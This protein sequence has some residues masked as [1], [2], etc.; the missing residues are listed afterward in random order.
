MKLIIRRTV[1][2]NH[3]CAIVLRTANRNNY[4]CHKYTHLNNRKSLI[5]QNRNGIGCQTKM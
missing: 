1:S 2:I 4:N 5:F 3:E